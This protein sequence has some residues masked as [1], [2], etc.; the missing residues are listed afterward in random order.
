M[1]KFKVGDEV[2]IIKTADKRSC[3]KG[4]CNHTGVVKY[5]REYRDET[6]YYLQLSD[7]VNPAQE[8]GWFVY[9]EEE[10]EFK[11]GTHNVYSEPPIRAEHD[12]GMWTCEF[13]TDCVPNIKIKEE[14]KEMELLDI[15]FNE[16]Q[17]EIRK[18]YNEKGVKIKCKDPVYKELTEIAKKYEGVRGVVCYAGCDFEYNDDIRKALV[19]NDRDCDVQIDAMY[20]LKKEIIARLDICETYEQKTNVL[21]VYGV[22][23]EQG[24]LNK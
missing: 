18:K 11:C 3:Y 9:E 8:Q 1:T 23:D 10:L 20:A 13:S 2:R 15:Y 12:F 19:K 16:K 6:T 21:K 14:K 7:R 17:R 22:I 5:I 24:K 4:L